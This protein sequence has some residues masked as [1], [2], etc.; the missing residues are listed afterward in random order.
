MVMVI[1]NSGAELLTWTEDTDQL[2]YVLDFTAI[3]PIAFQGTVPS[4]LHVV[5]IIEKIK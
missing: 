3:R 4:L 1:F 2:C 5:F